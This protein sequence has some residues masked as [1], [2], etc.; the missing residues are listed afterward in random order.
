MLNYVAVFMAV[1]LACT[2]I[3]VDVARLAHTA[4]EVQSV[5]DASAR[6]GALG[7]A[8]NG[9]L[10]DTGIPRAQLIG[11][12]N[13]MDGELA[14]V[15][16]ILV[17]EGRFN[18]ITKEFECCTTNS[19]CC[20]GGSWGEQTCVTSISCDQRS[21]ALSIPRVTV[22]N[23]FAGIFDFMSNGVLTANADP[24]APNSTTQVRK[25]A[26]AA[27]LGPSGGCEAPEGCAV[28]DW[29]CYCTNGVAPCLPIAAP[30][31]QFPETCTG[32]D[33]QLPTLQVSSNNTDTAAWT[34]FQHTPAS[35]NNIR[36][37]LDRPPTCNAPG[38]GS[39]IPAQDASGTTIDV[40]NGVNANSEN[41]PFGM[42]KCL[43]ENELGCS[44]D[45]NGNIGPGP[46]T[47][48]TIPVFE[49]EPCTTSMTGNY[50]II[51]FATVRID[52]VVVGSGANGARQIQITT[53][54][55]N[56]D[57]GQA[58]GGACLGTDCEVVLVR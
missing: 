2:A 9:G 36:D 39:P 6:A 20:S 57:T 38:N 46:G 23:I 26:I 48:F 31:C 41:G 24:S 15:D 44:I 50:P 29:S 30:S 11:S 25:L 28:G 55:S 45:G 22:Q 7:L 35:A 18:P 58:P 13:R 3:G 40:T 16:D 54:G 49:L 32:S 42:V 14:P 43:W 56:S 52:N 12:L 19:P 37:F 21:A 10:R 33:C 17:D 4:T 51:G 27:S 1:L 34:V 5:A 47:I 8:E 53:L